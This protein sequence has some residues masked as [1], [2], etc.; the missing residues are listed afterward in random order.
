MSL[1]APEPVPDVYREVGELRTEN[2]R[3]RGLP[4]DE[5]GRDTQRDAAILEFFDAWESRRRNQGFDAQYPVSGRRRNRRFC[6]A[7]I[8]LCH[9]LKLIPWPVFG[10]Y[11]PPT[12]NP[13]W[14]DEAEKP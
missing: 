13:S 2:K 4:E 14:D 12:G 6:D 9:H 7:F 11:G 10:P 1:E 5:I 8:G 3:L